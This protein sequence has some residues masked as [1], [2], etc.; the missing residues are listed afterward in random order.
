MSKFMDMKKVAEV[1]ESRQDEFLVL[2]VCP[3]V[4]L[5]VF[6]VIDPDKASNQKGSQR[7]ETV[8]LGVGESATPV[9]APAPA[10]APQSDANP[11]STGL[12]CMTDSVPYLY[13][14][15]LEEEVRNGVML[16]LQETVSN[17][18]SRALLSELIER[19]GEFD[20]LAE[21]E[22]AL[23]Q[24]IEFLEDEVV[25]LKKEGKDTKDHR[26]KLQQL[27]RE[28]EKVVEKVGGIMSDMYM[29]VGRINAAR[30]VAQQSPPTSDVPEVSSN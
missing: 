3:L 23:A 11:I 15:F 2:F 1:L 8:S 14:E 24:E 9:P 10:P 13:D 29:V 21:E 20:A 4:L 28:I 26:K 12:F 25:E 18:V 5:V 6:F 19:V 17:P 27:E 7:H 30:D 22:M 16:V